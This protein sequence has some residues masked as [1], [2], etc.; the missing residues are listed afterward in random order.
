MLLRKVIK[1]VAPRC[2]ILTLKCTKFSFCL[3][4]RWGAYS[5]SPDLLAGFK[6]STSKGGEKLRKEGRKGDQR[7]GSHPIL[8]S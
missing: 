2:H 5:A 6:R 8:K 7:V 3:K 4:P 1:F